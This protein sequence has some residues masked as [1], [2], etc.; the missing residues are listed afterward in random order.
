MH[1]FVYFSWLVLPSWVSVPY[2]GFCQMPDFVHGHNLE[3]SVIVYGMIN[4]KDFFKAGVFPTFLA[5][6]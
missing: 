3:T 6:E 5:A 4:M 2:E 1:G